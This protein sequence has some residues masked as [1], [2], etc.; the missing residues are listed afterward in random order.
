[1]FL[2]ELVN[3]QYD[4]RGWSY[5]LPRLKYLAFLGQR[6]QDASTYYYKEACGLI[7]SAPNL[8]S[9]VLPD[10]QGSSEPWIAQQFKNVPWDI[11]LE[12]LSKLSVS[13]IRRNHLRTIL[14]GCPV[15]EDLEYCREDTGFDVDI[16]CPEEDLSAVKGTLRRLCYSIHQDDLDRSSENELEILDEDY[17]P[18][19]TVMSGLKILEI[20]RLLLWGTADDVLGVEVGQDLNHDEHE[21]VEIGPT[22]EV[23]LQDYGQGS[24]QQTV[25]ASCS[26]ETF[27]MQMTTP[28]Y[29]MSRLPQS[30]ETLCIG[31]I[32]C[33]PAMYRDAAAL[34]RVATHRFPHLRQLILEVCGY[35]PSQGEIED[36][37]CVF[38]NANITCQVLPREDGKSG[39]PCHVFPPENLA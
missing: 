12:F 31:R 24:D 7:A 30:L 13:G 20:Q 27:K 36:L 39:R 17:Y 33:W 5:P 35:W 3:M 19:W 9:L 29:F 37:I 4:W 23:H 32:I 10:C 16:L 14:L 26:Q 6:V 2:D 22:S 18:S 11:S 1:M 21:E 28:E 38:N 34:A 25:V 8:C 15:L